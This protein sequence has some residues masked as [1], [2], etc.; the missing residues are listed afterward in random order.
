MSNTLRKAAR[1]EAWS[2]SVGRL[3]GLIGQWSVRWSIRWTPRTAVA[4]VAG[5]F[6]FAW[7]FLRIV[8]FLVFRHP[9]AP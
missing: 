6:L 3:Y 1:I 8:L 4:A 9:P 7:A 2:A 5:A